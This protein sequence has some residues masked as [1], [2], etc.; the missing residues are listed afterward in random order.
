MKIL[1]TGGKS[2][3]ALKLLKA[4]TNDKVVLADYGDVPIFT[5][6][7]YQFISLGAK[8]ESALAHNLLNNCLDEGVDTILPLHDFEIEALSKAKILYSEFNINILLPEATKI[9]EGGIKTNSWVIYKH[10]ELIFSTELNNEIN[11]LANK[12]KI[13]GAFYMTTDCKL[14]IITI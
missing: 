13:S 12:D 7:D 14:K 5:S 4:F 8:N 1:L 6:N 2:A 11:N 10:G 3:V 9:Y